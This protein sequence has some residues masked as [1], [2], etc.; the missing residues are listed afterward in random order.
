[1]CQESEILGREL[2]KC[3]GI[4]TQFG[5]QTTTKKKKKNKYKRPQKELRHYEIQ[6]TADIPWSSCVFIA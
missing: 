4:N 6:S 1:M 2:K 3:V 5:T